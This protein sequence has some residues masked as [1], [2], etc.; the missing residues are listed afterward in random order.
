MT[1][2]LFCQAGLRHIFPVHLLLG[3][4]VLF[5]EGRVV[6][7]AGSAPGSDPPEP[8]INPLRPDPLHPG[9]PLPAHSPG[10]QPCLPHSAGPGAPPASSP[11]RP[12]PPRA[13]RRRRARVA[14]REEGLEEGGSGSG[15]T[16]ISVPAVSSGGG[17]GGGGSRSLPPAPLRDGLPV[18][19]CAGAGTPFFP[20]TEGRDHREERGEGRAPSRSLPPSSHSRPPFQGSEGVTLGGLSDF[21][22]CA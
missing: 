15:P 11:P 17:G 14:E 13:P 12:P 6:E 5:P 21:S 2:F 9:H 18:R 19:F 4:V 3:S 1:Q 8:V 22:S 20:V 7:G 10:P 16:C